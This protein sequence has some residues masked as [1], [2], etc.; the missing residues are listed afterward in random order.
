MANHATQ[1][2]RYVEQYG[3]DVVEDFIEVCL[4]L[5]NLIDPHSPFIKR[6]DGRNGEVDGDDGAAERKSPAK[7]KSK[8][9]MDSFINPKDVLEKQA[10]FE[11]EERKRKKEKFPEKPQRDVLKFLLEN[12]SLE[13]WQSDI[14]AIFREEAYYFAPQGQT[15]IMNE[16]WATYWH[17]KIMTEK[18]LTDAEVIDYADHHSGTVATSPGRLN[19]YKLGVELFRDIEERWNKGKFG[20]EYNECDDWVERKK[21]DK[22]T[23]VGRQK[24]FEVRRLYNDLMFIDAFLTPEF[25]LEHKLF[26]YAY[27][28]RNDMYEISDRDFKKVKEKLLAGLTNFGQPFIFVVD[29]NYLNRNELYLLH[30]HEGVEL[31]L[32]EARDTLLNLFKIW[33]RPV[34]IETILDDA[35]TLLSFDGEEHN[36]TEID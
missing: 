21:W 31:Q 1:I 29:A 13:K 3:A 22:Q 18:S 17:S 33:K 5:E 35:K 4:S 36:E 23:G 6:D 26:A 32:D 8:S 19:P 20:K 15:K 11:E 28:D 2:R 7:L 16:G 12:A 10:K 34:H 24:I 9:Y 14:L 30:Q 25:C 27:N